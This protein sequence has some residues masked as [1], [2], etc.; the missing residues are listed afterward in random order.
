MIFNFSIAFFF[1]PGGRTDSIPI[2]SMLPT[3]SDNSLLLHFFV[4]Y[5]FGL[6]TNCDDI[7]GQLA[8]VEPVKLTAQAAVTQCL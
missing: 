3:K 6:Q 8:R 4:R 2:N 5:R 1:N 7:L